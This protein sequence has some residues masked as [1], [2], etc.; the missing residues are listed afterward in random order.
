MIREVAETD[1]SMILEWRNHPNVRR[2]ML[3]QH[4]IAWEEHSKWFHLTI[5]DPQ[6][7]IYIVEE[8]GQPLGFVQFKGVFPG[9]VSD[10]GFYVAPN[11]SKGTGKKIGATALNYAFSTLKLHK[12]C[13]QA[14]ETNTP[15]IE[16][17]KR[18]GFKQEGI[19]REQQRIQGIYHTMVC[20]GL[21]SEEWRSR[22]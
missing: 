18:L 22:L 12:I 4:E 2:F 9:G 6:K 19:L 1:L 14:L 20:F 15:S 8:S 17:H 7:K 16:F 11:S 13:G 3:N 5:L 21:L 10:W